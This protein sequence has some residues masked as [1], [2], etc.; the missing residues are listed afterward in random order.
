MRWADWAQVLLYSSW[1]KHRLFQRDLK[2]KQQWPGEFPFILPQPHRDEMLQ[3]P[4]SRPSQ[5]N[6]GKCQTS[7]SEMRPGEVNG[8]F[9]GPPPPPPCTT[10]P[11][12]HAVRQDEDK[13]P[14]KTVTLWHQKEHIALYTCS[15]WI[16][17]YC[18]SLHILSCMVMNCH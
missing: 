6:N 13:R 9:C 1:R 16:A 3:Q 12:P 8:T 4:D 2:E 15:C 14:T 17:A 11:T 5:N 18:F 7:V 10:L